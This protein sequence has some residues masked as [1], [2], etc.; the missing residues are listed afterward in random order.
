MESRRHPTPWSPVPP[1]EARSLAASV[2][3]AVAGG[4]VSGADVHDQLADAAERVA[5]QLAGTPELA[6]AGNL[7][8][9][10]IGPRRAP[11]SQ[12]ID[13]TVLED[14]LRRALVQD[15]A[16]PLWQDY[17]AHLTAV[18]DARP[19]MHPLRDAV[20]RR[21]P[22]VAPERLAALREATAA[23]RAHRRTD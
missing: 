19:R 5:P 6:A 12:P 21:K 14:V 7:Y 3:A 20:L 11:G 8:K 15:P 16:D 1:D 17:L 4:T 10:V 23:L 18:E 13:T 9:V 2:V 22:A